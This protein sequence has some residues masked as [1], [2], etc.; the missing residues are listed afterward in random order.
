MAATTNQPG[1]WINPALDMLLNDDDPNKM[2][3]A[4]AQRKIDPRTGKGVIIDPVED[5]FME[6][7][8]RSI[9]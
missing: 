7:L 1:Y 9:K 8:R 4:P 5:P 6:S 3:Y 2:P